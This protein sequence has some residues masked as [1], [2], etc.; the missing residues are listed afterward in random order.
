[1]TGRHVGGYLQ[2]VGSRQFGPRF[3][4]SF[5]GDRFRRSAAFRDVGGRDVSLL[6]VTANFLF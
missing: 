2:A 5:E 1:M 4:L 3:S 6:K